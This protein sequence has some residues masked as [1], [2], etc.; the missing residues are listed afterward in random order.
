MSGTTATRRAASGAK[1]G[2]AGSAAAAAA[3]FCRDDDGRFGAGSLSR[4]AAGMKFF[5]NR[6]AR[7][8]DAGATG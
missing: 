3:V 8:I 5:A 2:G 1:V 7:R 6:R 4:D